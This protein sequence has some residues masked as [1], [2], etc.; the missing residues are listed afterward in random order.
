MWCFENST[1]R[2][3]VFEA[4]WGYIRYKNLGPL[5]VVLSPFA[6]H[7]ITRR[8]YKRGAW[9]SLSLRWLCSTKYIAIAIFARVLIVF[10]AALIRFLQMSNGFSAHNHEYFLGNRSRSNSVCNKHSLA[11][12]CVHRSAIAFIDPW[13]SQV[14]MCSLWARSHRFLSGM[15]F[16]WFWWLLTLW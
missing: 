5:R 12:Y 14:R 2:S 8:S 6:V 15:T 7:S 3:H 9:Y 11:I 10:Q 1:G 16:C 13:H 4:S